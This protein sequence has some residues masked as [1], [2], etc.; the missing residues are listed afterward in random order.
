MRKLRT[1]NRSIRGLVEVCKQ[2]NG[3]L[4]TNDVNLNK[5]ASVQNV[6]VINLNDVANALKPRYIPG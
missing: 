6:Q 1:D 5:L 3:R 2:H 4:V